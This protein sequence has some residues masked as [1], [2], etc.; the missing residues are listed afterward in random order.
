MAPELLKEERPRPKRESDVYAFGG[1]ILA[2]MSGKPPFGGLREVPILVRIGLDQMP[3]S[4]EHPA[5]P[6]DDEL[7]NLM[8]RCW[9]INP[10]ARPTLRGHIFHEQFRQGSTTRLPRTT[11]AGGRERS[12]MDLDVLLTPTRQVPQQLEQYLRLE[13]YFGGPK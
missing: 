7:W 6:P 9:D 4:E 8:R 13:E 5:L 12:D 10:T 1:L 2:V 11:E 3:K